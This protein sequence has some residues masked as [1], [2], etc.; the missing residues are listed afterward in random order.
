LEIL[1]TFERS[2][3]EIVVTYGLG[4]ILLAQLGLLV[5]LVVV[6]VGG[7]GLIGLR[8]KLVGNGAAILGVQVLVAVGLA[9]AVA[10]T[11]LEFGYGGVALVACL[12]EGAVSDA[13]LA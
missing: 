3:I 8:S 10:G 6:V 2:C 11:L 5:G 12:V 13:G 1:Y 4:G 9:F 7:V